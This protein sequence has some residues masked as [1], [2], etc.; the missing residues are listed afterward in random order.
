MRVSLRNILL[1]FLLSFVISDGLATETI[2]F[3][4]GDKIC[5]IGNSITHGGT[6]HAF[7]QAYCATR[8][9]DIKLEFHNCG[10]SGD[11]AGGMLMR[12]DEDVL[13]HDPD[14]AF[15]MTGMNDVNRSLYTGAAPDSANLALRQQAMD[16]YYAQTDELARRLIDN[17]IQPIFMTP[18]IYDQTVLIGQENNFGV[19]DALGLCAEHIRELA[20]EYDAPLVDLYAAMN[21]INLKGQEND[22]TFTI[23][24]PDRVHP[25]A[26][27]HLIMAFEIIKSLL[28]ADHVSDTELR[29]EKKA[30]ELLTFEVL[31]PA[32]PFPLDESLKP[33]LEFMP[34]CEAYNREMLSVKKLARGN[35]I[36]MID[37]AAIGTFSSR[38]LKSGINLSAYQSPPQYQQAEAIMDLCFKYNQV[39]NQLRVLYM[40]EFRDL[41]DYRGDGRLAD[42]KAY[43]EAKCETQRD[44]SWYPYMIRTTAAYFEN[45]PKREG[46]E[47]ELVNLRDKIYTGN[48]P[49]SHRYQLVKE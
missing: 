46:F 48:K 9:P 27:G 3:K 33:T 31:E 21:S 19:N 18:T 11:N 23:V 34:W 36:L 14:Y 20:E 44:K 12:F 13:V 15:L 7:L 28:P 24:G 6:Y 2:A 26:P 43:L 37:D 17:K 47:Q 5:F 49:N 41:K 1:L 35:Y 40:I 4:D 32:L 29:A 22:P 8:Y 10:I 39:Q 30:S 25:G 38:E 45:L 16:A 42:K